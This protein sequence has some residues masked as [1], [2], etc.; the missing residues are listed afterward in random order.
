MSDKKDNIKSIAEEVKDLKDVVIDVSSFENECKEASTPTPN[1]KHKTVPL[2]YG[3][4]GAE[5]VAKKIDAFSIEF[6]DSFSDKDHVFHKT[7][8]NGIKEKFIDMI[9]NHNS[10]RI[11][12]GFTKQQYYNPITREAGD[13]V[14]TFGSTPKTYCA[15]INIYE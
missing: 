14:A 10:L 7:M 13:I 11:K 15:S 5:V 1:T 8:S 12:L 4:I 2:V 9:A 3:D 6:L